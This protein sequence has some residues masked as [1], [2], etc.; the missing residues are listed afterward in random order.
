MI[1]KITIKYPEDYINDILGLVD[2]NDFSEVYE[3][4]ATVYRAEMMERFSK[5]SRGGGDWPPLAAS[6][7]ARRRKG[8][9]GKPRKT[10][11]LINTGTLYNT[12]QP[13]FGMPGQIQE[14]L[15]K[16]VR[17]GI[18]GMDMHP[19]GGGLTI[20]QIASYH[21]EGGGRLPKRE[22]LVEPS[23]ETKEVMGK[24]LGDKIAE[25]LNE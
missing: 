3:A 19:S 13:T 18:G 5:F 11:I 6:T 14:V 15:D 2:K 25:Y 7:I 21:Q 8:K 9:S 23:E 20:G 24:M 1:I 17:V 12:L 22:I 4:W 10:S 16:G